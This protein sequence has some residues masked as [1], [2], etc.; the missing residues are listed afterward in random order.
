MSLD[1]IE[2]SLG[3]SKANC[4]WANKWTQARNR[5]NTRMV[6]FHGETKPLAQWA[7]ELGIKYDTLYQR[8]LR[9]IPLE[10]ALKVQVM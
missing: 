9:N 6:E 10:V 2:N 5:T 1:R 4:R 7:E 3:Y 8:I